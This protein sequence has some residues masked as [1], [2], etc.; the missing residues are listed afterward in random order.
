MFNLT[1]ANPKWNV[2]ARTARAKYDVSRASSKKKYANLQCS[3]GS[4]NIM[5]LSAKPRKALLV[6]HLF[7]N[8]QKLLID[9]RATKVS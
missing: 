1:R 3:T 5:T 6:F 9:P 7:C 2:D 4:L 8:R